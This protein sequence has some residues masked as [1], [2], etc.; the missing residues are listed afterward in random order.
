M[1]SGPAAA[2]WLLMTRVRFALMVCCLCVAALLAA[3]TVRANPL[4]N[5]KRAIGG[6][7]V[8]L[9]PLFRWWTNR[10][11]ARPLWAWTHITGTVVATNSWGWTVEAR[12]DPPPA[13]THGS[14]RE[15]ASAGGRI[16]LALRHPPVSDLADFSQLSAESQ[17]LIDQSQALSNTVKTAANQLREIGPGNHRSRF[18]AAQ[19][20]QL[21]LVENQAK[22]QLANL[23]PLLADCRAKLAAFQ[24]S[25]KYILDCLALDMGEDVN[26]LPL[27]D[28]G[29]P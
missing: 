6:Q 27:Y 9:D 13:L 1:T 16:K 18:V 11:G 26:G 20:H 5:P 21:H 7:T 28:Y 3:A 8:D 10:H 24:D 22:A 23:R 2:I 29:V 17:A 19:V 25:K 4:K 12:L 14:A 15:R